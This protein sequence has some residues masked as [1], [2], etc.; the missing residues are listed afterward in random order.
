MALYAIKLEE[1][2]RNPVY[3]QLLEEGVRKR[4]AERWSPVVTLPTSKSGALE[5]L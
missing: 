4:R 5:G 3:S 2:K 1:R